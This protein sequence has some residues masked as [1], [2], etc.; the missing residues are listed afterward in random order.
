MGFM[1]LDV[2]LP[3]CFIPGSVCVCY[4]W[5]CVRVVIP[6]VYKGFKESR[7]QTYEPC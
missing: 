1:C 3:V 7:F 5:L 2:Y 6:K 4:T